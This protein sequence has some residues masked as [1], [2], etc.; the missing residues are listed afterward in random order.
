MDNLKTDLLRI[1]FLIPAVLL[2]AAVL[3]RR[4]IFG[5]AAAA[6]AALLVWL[7][8]RGDRCPHCGTRI[9][10]KKG[11]CCPFCDGELTEK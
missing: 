5:I 7:L 10:G 9:V 6:S 2:I 11:D 3:C 4:W 8:L 1:L